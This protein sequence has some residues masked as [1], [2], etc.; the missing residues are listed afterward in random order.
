MGVFLCDCVK[1]MHVVMLRA[2]AFT[3]VFANIGVWSNED[4]RANTKQVVFGV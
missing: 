2:V 1:W 4:I 3:I